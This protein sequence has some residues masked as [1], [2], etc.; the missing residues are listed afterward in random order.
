M[1]LDRI[2]AHKRQEVAARQR[3]MPLSSFQE[4]IKPSTRS[5]Y[6]ALAKPGARFVMEYKKASPSRG[7]IRSDFTA[8]AAADAYGDCADAISVVVDRK[9]FGG[10]LDDLHVI[11]S[12]VRQPVLC[13]DIVVS[14]YQV[15]EAR[16]YGADAVLLMLSVLDDHDYRTC[17][18]AARRLALDVVTEIHDGDELAR[19]IALDARIIGINNRDLRHLKV[20]L[21]TTRRLAR[22]VPRDRLII[23]ESGI[24]NHRDVRNLC[25]HADAFLVGTSLMQAARV[26]LAARRLVHGRV[27]VCGHAEA[28]G[29][30]DA[31]KAGAIYGGLVFAQQSRRRVSRDQARHIS[32]RSPMP[33]VGVFV[34]QGVGEVADVA[35]EVA[36]HAVQLHGDEDAGYISDLRRRLPDGCRIW[37]AIRVRG[38]PPR[39]LPVD[40]DRVLFDSYM[41]ALWGGTGQR[42]DWS[43]LRRRRDRGEIILAGGLAEHCAGEAAALGAWA[44]DVSSG[45][46]RA[47]GVK[48]GAKM[49]AFLAALRP[50]SRADFKGRDR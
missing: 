31:Y 21:D 40:A 39:R 1:V 24:G 4:R 33:M 41:P 6:G 10:N 49:N 35:R 22:L 25:R 3:R 34:N 48:D 13:K 11:R 47:P 2:V 20:D 45:V 12:R 28:R 30:G 19:A 50:P 38:A 46:E 27:K 36:L 37:K 23:S 5:L 18:E 29:P 8:Q 43:V 9:F 17:R 7:A 14:P 44:L 26:D 32:E 42:F 16:H 15:F